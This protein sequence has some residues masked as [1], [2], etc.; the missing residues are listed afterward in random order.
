MHDSIWAGQTLV[1]L[2]YA[3]TL[4]VWA[5]STAILL[6]IPGLWHKV[7]Q[8]YIYHRT[9]QIGIYIARWMPPVA[10]LLILKL[11]TA[12]AL[13]SIGI[14]LGV[15][16]GL[17][18][19]EISARLYLL[20]LAIGT[21]TLLV[22]SGVWRAFQWV[23]FET[24]IPR[25]I[26]VEISLDQTVVA[27]LRLMLLLPVQV[28]T[29]STLGAEYLLGGTLVALVLPSALRIVQT[30][31]RLWGSPGW[32]VYVFLYL[33]THEILPWGYLIAV[34]YYLAGQASANDMSA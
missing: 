28:A 5:G 2:Q 24:F 12:L 9:D 16:Y 17:L 34:M 4:V 20:Y 25:E 22:L 18:P 14:H 21:A 7:A 30:M 8:S 32:Y 11:L 26:G 31:R 27:H 13:T 23:W 33:C 19:Q 10:Y 6:R 15:S 29:L 3:T 1:D